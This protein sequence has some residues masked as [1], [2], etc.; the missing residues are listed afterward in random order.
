MSE[1]SDFVD[2]VKARLPVTDPAIK[3]DIGGRRRDADRGWPRVCAIP[4]SATTQPGRGYFKNA[5]TVDGGAYGQ[6]LYSRRLRVVWEIWARDYTDAEALLK[7]IGVAFQDVAGQSDGAFE[8]NGETWLS[9]ERGSA[10]ES[11]TLVELDTV[12]SLAVLASSLTRLVLHGAPAP[13]DSAVTV[14]TTGKLTA[15]NIPQSENDPEIVGVTTK[16]ND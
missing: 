9:E 2:A 10:A 13:S 1:L 15:T 11:G 5:P 8:I 7:A 12:V 16:G 4:L 6:H 14:P 3:W